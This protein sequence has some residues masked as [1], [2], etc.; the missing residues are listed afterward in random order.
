MVTDGE[1]ERD[2]MRRKCIGLP[3][4][5]GIFFMPRDLLT[6]PH[7][8]MQLSAPISRLLL[9]EQVMSE[10]EYRKIISN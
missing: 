6:I 8:R 3:L 7:F 1:A 5:E 10:G 2:N 9:L 4:A